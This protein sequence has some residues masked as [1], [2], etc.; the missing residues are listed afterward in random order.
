MSIEDVVLG[1]LL[2]A[3]ELLYKRS[4]GRIGHRALGVPCLLLHT[5]GRRSGQPRTSSLVYAKDGED[6]IVVASAGGAEKH[7]AWF[8]N[9]VAHPDVEFQVGTTRR[10]GTAR[11][12]EASDPDYARLWQLMNA[13]NHDRYATYQTKPSRPIPLV[14]IA[15]R[16]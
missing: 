4:G 11:V 6:L 10:P 5:T 3:H 2:R 1:P 7:P 14:A 16:D 12:I 15:P 8:H 9:V 13:S